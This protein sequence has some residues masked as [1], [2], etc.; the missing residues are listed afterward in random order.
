[1]SLRK[2]ALALSI[3]LLTERIVR[4]RNRFCIDV[5][6]SVYFFGGALSFALVPSLPRSMRIFGCLL[7]MGSNVVYLTKHEEI[8]A[9]LLPPKYVAKKQRWNK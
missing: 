8:L 2:M 9:T 4:Y 5:F 6:V 7:M 3:Y 1:M